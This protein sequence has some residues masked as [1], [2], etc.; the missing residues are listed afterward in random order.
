MLL[1]F[2]SFI[3]QVV[4]SFLLD[5]LILGHVPEFPSLVGAAMVIIGVVVLATEKRDPQPALMVVQSKAQGHGWEA[6]EPL[7]TS[8]CAGNAEEENVL[9]IIKHEN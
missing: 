6:E 9:L 1:M 5:L 4:F 2:S 3:S 7:L 8:E